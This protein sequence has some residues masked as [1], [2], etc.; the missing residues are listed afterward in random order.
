MSETTSEPCGSQ[1]WSFSL[2]I[3]STDASA[4][5]ALCNH[6]VNWVRS[7]ETT[8]NRVN[9][10]EASG[11]PEDD[12]AAAQA[13]EIKAMLEIEDLTYLITDM[14]ALNQA[15]VEA[16][17]RALD[18]LTSVPTW[19]RDSLLTI[20]RSIDRDQL[21]VNALLLTG[22]PVPAPR[23]GWLSRLSLGIAKG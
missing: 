10:A 23:L 8:A 15:E 14:H 16:K 2:A 7:F 5:P 11:L 20:R 12:V 6:V 22:S 13:E 3:G 1:N 9:K 19:E 21:E 18:A 4:L 17:K